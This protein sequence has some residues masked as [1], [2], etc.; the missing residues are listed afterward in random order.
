MDLISYFYARKFSCV[1][2]SNGYVL[3]SNKIETEKKCS[4]C[5]LC[6][7]SVYIMWHFV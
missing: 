4:E 5:T 6:G 3:Y 2:L 7:I 1:Y